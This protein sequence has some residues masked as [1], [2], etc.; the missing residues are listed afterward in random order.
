MNDKNTQKI[1]GK[2][3]FVPYLALRARLFS[4]NNIEVNEFINELFESN[5]FI[6]EG[7]Y[8]PVSEVDE[9]YLKTNTE[10]M[11]A[12]LIHQF[13]ML[14]MRDK[15]RK[16]GE[17]LISNFTK[18]GYCNIS[19]SMVA[20]KFNVKVQEV[21]AILKKIQAGSPSGIGARNLSECFILQLERKESSVSTKVKHII[22]NHI[23]ELAKEKYKEISKKVGINI[24]TLKELRVKLICLCPSPGLMFA[25]VKGKRNIPDIIIETDGEALNVYLNKTSRREI[26]VNQKYKK[27]LSE[28][29]DPKTIKFLQDFF[30]KAKWAKMS[31]EERDERLLNIGRSIA[32][33]ENDFLKGTRL[34]PKKMSIETFCKTTVSSPSVI[35]RLVQNKYVAT[36]R[37]IYPLHFFVQRKNV[38]YNEEELK[39]K[40]KKIISSEDKRLPLSDGDVVK[41]LAAMKINI[42]RRTV[43]KYRNILGISPCSKR[44]LTK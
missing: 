32:E 28:A 41:K 11:Y 30:Q 4:M 36:P 8:V 14:K 24:D 33:N 43:T 29:T 21:E 31:I 15:E 19:L 38:P 20:K 5:P 39:E 9:N 44:R 35:S 22:N 42:K 25:E 40:I 26:V 10:D 23:E 37:G 2:L 7:K 17:F 34:Y 18:E 13:R 16:I 27:M 1:K 12:F 3:S 6:E